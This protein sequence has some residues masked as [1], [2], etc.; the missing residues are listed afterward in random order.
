[1]KAPSFR[2]TEKSDG[3]FILHY[4]S[5]RPGLEFIVIGLVKTVALKLH[6]TDVEC[7]II[8]SKGEEGCD[9]VQFEIIEKSL[10]EKEI[11][12][13][14]SIFLF[15]DELNDPKEKI[16]DK[17][18]N[19]PLKMGTKKVMSPRS[20][21]KA[22]P[23]HIIF[24]KNMN[25]VQCGSSIA[26]LVPELKIKSYKLTDI[27]T[28]IRPHIS[29]EFQHI[30]SQIMSVF[31]LARQ[32]DPF[33]KNSNG[34]EDNFTRFKGQMVYLPEKQYILFQCSPAIMSLEDLFM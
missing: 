19:I 15:L 24:D 9:H 33:A 11:N 6:K 17:K 8:K 4:Y 27:F 25:I 5:D 26:R 34:S 3:R 14:L 2:C 20:F 32:N 10:S 7:K 18:I 23:F 29:F 21:C 13:I 22:F 12:I 28:I 1:M 16:L 31:V 30:Y